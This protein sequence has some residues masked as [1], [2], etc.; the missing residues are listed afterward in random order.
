M[1]SLWLPQPETIRNSCSRP[2]IG[3]VRKGAFSFSQATS[4]GTGFIAAN[5]MEDLVKLQ[6]K[7]VVLVRNPNCRQYRPVIMNVIID[8]S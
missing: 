1:R 7:N 2:V 4:C 8:Q 6:L 5:C 3:F